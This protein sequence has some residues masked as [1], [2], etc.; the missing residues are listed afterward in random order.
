MLSRI[1]RF[2]RAD[3]LFYGASLFLAVECVYFGWVY[4]TS[5]PAPPPLIEQ[6]PDGL[7]SGY[8]LGR[9]HGHNAAMEQFNLPVMKIFVPED[10]RTY[11]YTSDRQLPPNDNPNEE[12][13]GYVDGYHRALDLIYCPASGCNIPQ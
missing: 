9:F 8:E 6:A 2:D 4:V 5:P 7:L 10:V 1:K 13:R 12:Q 11:K 3:W